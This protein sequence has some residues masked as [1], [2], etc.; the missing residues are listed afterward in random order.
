MDNKAYQDGMK[1]TEALAEIEARNLGQGRPL[2]V[3][4]G[5]EIDMKAAMPHYD[6]NLGRRLERRRRNVFTHLGRRAGDTTRSKEIVTPG[7][8]TTPVSAAGKGYRPA[9]SMRQVWR[10][11]K[12]RLMPVTMIGL[13]EQ[14][15]ITEN[16]SDAR[17]DTWIRQT[18]EQAKGLDGLRADLE[19][20]AMAIQQQG[21]MNDSTRGQLLQLEQ[22]LKLGRAYLPRAVENAPV[23]YTLEPMKP[24]RRARA[25]HSKSKRAGKARSRAG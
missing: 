3:K 8:Y 23:I 17:M 11:L 21:R 4:L 25:S 6:H 9:G 7:R 15:R 5:D 1:N 2:R 22:H 10:R 12:R 18:G 14:I 16:Y 13:L 24:S 19:A 20:I